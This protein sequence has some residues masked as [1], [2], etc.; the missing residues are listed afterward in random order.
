MQVTSDEI[1]VRLPA[2]LR[3]LRRSVGPNQRIPD[4]EPA[5]PPGGGRRV[6]HVPGNCRRKP[7]P[8]CH[9]ALRSAIVDAIT[10]HETL[11]FRDNA[12]FEALQ[13]QSASRHDRRQGP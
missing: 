9:A 13:T 8:A 5:F 11:F 12:P 10:T 1:A 4:R 7:A 2:D 6:R 3:T